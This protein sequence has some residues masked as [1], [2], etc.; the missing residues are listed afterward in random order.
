MCG[1][2]GGGV[3][4]CELRFLF[5]GLVSKRPGKCKVGGVELWK[6]KRGDGRSVGGVGMGWDGLS[7]LILGL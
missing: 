2:W 1:G 4:G 5:C 3:G 7:W 6:G